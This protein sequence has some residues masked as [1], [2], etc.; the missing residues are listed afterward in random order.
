MSSLKNLLS[1]SGCWVVATLAPAETLV[2]FYRGGC[3]THTVERQ[4]VQLRVLYLKSIYMEVIGKMP[5]DT[6]K[7]TTIC[8]VYPD[9]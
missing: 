8:G 9:N 5:R 2:L 4:A 7:S 1:S 6:P 3:W